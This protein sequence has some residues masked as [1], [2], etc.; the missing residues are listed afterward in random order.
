MGAGGQEMTR[1]MAQ[2]MTD[3]LFPGVQ[4][5]D[6]GFGVG[7]SAM[8]F[9]ELY[10]ATV[11]GIDL[12]PI[13]HAM[14]SK[15]LRARNDRRR[16]QGQQPLN[17]TFQVQDASTADFDDE[18][19]HVIYSRD[20]LL[21]LD[22]P[23][24]EAL[25]RKFTK[26]LK[27]G[28]RICIAD[29]CLGAQSTA[30]GK[31]TPAF[32]T[33]LQARGYH[34]W[35]PVNYAKAVERAG[36]QDAVG[37]D[38]AFWYCATCQKELD[39]VLLAPDDFLQSHPEETLSNLEKTYWDKIQMTLR[40][41]RSYVLV[42]ATKD[43]PYMDLKKQVCEAYTKLSKE[44]YVIGCD[45]NVSARVD[46]DKIIMT[47]T[48]IAVPDLTPSKMVLCDSNG[49]PIGGNYKPTSEKDLHTLIYQSRPDVG[50]IV[51]FHSVY[52]S[53][54]ACV[55]QSL[56]PAHYAVCELLCSAEHGIPKD[57]NRAVQCAPYFTYG[58]WPLAMATAA[59][60]GQN[61]A[62]LM[63]NHG[64]IVVAEDLESAMF[65]AARLERECEIYWRSL[66]FGKPVPLTEQ[67]MHDLA[68]RDLTYGQEQL[69]V[70]VLPD[71]PSATSLCTDSSSDDELHGFVETKPE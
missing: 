28:G 42:T 53:A 49:K 18:S 45:G 63:A 31:P 44:G 17:C 14:A 22:G 57:T 15:E 50:A 27:P 33:Y 47:P 61:Q 19:F 5:L 8:E 30:T 13:G 58:T 2:K 10:G 66:Q 69:P 3:V 62:V 7:G 1:R 59:A 51:H 64:A 9:C 43:E 46:G 60:L 20:T 37:E 65:R 4:M 34:M 40:G 29:Y 32:Q 55:R 54:L 38:L 21:H 11:R 70:V 24:K 23:T 25:F 36:L 68:R 52:A 26:W 39:R 6:I 41:D 56:P 12:N 16:D 48:G 71:T 67:E 35:T